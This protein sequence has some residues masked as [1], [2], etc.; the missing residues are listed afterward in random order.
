[1]R[2]CSTGASRVE[3]LGESEEEEEEEAE[4]EGEAVGLKKRK[5]RRPGDP[6]LLREWRRFQRAFGRGE[7]VQIGGR[8]I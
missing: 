1:M 3:G 2:S 7:F 8:G 5:L 6:G 4:Q